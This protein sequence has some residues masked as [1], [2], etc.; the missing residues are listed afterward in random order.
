[1]EFRK[2]WVGTASIGPENCVTSSAFTLGR[3]C[4]DCGRTDGA[5]LSMER[6]PR[7]P[8]LVVKAV[9]KAQVWNGSPP[10]PL[11]EY[12]LCATVGLSHFRPTR[13]VLRL[14]VLREFSKELRQLMGQ[15]KGGGTLFPEKRWLNKEFRGLLEQNIF[16]NFKLVLETQFIQMQSMLRV[17]RA[18]AALHGLVRRPERVRMPLLLGLY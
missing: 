4:K 7:A 13:P 6:E 16:A 12:S 17:W 8:E 5:S 1:M 14:F 10:C 15:F 3:E 11:S 2:R 9:P 18:V